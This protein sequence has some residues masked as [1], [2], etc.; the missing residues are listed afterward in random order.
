VIDI[1][2]CP[3]NPLIQGSTWEEI[4]SLAQKLEAA[5]VTIINTGIGWHEARIPTI[6]TVTIHLF[7]PL[8]VEVI[9]CAL[10]AFFSRNIQT[11]FTFYD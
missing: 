5:G 9:V 3:C 2:S 7:S 1:D 8:L 11:L 4:V 10:L 6:A